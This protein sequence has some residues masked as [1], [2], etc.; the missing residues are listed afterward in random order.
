MGAS[1]SC[2]PGRT[3]ALSRSLRSPLRSSAGV[4]AAGIVVPAGALELP[5]GDDASHHWDVPV[6]ADLGACRAAGV[7]SDPKVRG[8]DKN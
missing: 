3:T 5:H 1:A 8:L 7:A 6:A 2:I 4:V